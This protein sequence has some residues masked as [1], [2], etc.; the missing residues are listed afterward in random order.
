MTSIGETLRRERLGRGLDLSQVSRDTRITVRFLE[1]IEADRFDK[2]PGGVFTRSFVRQYARALGLDEEEIAAELQRVLGAQEEPVPAPL[3]PEIKMPKVAQWE[4]FGKRLRPSSSLPA[5]AMVVVVMLVCSGIYTWWQ[6]SKTK[7][8]VKDSA[9]AIAQTA[10]P[11]AAIPISTPAQAPAP[12]ATDTSTT[13][14]TA[15]RVT[16]VVA[17][18]ETTP[19]PPAPAEAS[20]A[21]LGDPAGTVHVSLKAEEPTWVAIT[22]D[23]KRVYSGT[24][25]PNESRVLNAAGSVHVLVGNAGGLGVTYNGQ[26]VPLGPKGQVRILQVTPEHGAQVLPPKPADPITDTL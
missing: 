3:E 15:T 21:T 9:P 10:Q 19:A 26:S 8:A 4:G 16:P 5:L 24:L 18:T 22:I 1:S 12:A 17:N 11:P 20:T 7:P 25:Q 13:P 2:L 14:G 23:G 6:A